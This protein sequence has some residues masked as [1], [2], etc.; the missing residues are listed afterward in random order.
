MLIIWHCLDGFG[1][2]HAL[3]KKRFKIGHWIFGYNLRKPFHIWRHIY[4]CF[5]LFLAWKKNDT[6]GKMQYLLGNQKIWK[7]ESK[8]L[9]LNFSQLD[10]ISRKIKIKIIWI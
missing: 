1:H 3:W 6:K 7:I 10:S 9:D 2:N 4:K 5:K 8:E